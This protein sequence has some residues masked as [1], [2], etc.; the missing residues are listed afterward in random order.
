MT[1]KLIDK[2]NDL[3]IKYGIAIFAL[4]ILVGIIIFKLDKAKNAA[5]ISYNETKEKYIDQVYQNYY[6]K[7]YENAER[8]NHVSNQVAIEISDIS[9]IFS[10]EVL[11]INDVEF[12]VEN[13]KENTDN[14]T[15]WIEVPGHGIMIVNLQ[16]SEFIVDAERHYVIARVPRPKLDINQYGI[17]ADKINELLWKDDFWNGS[18]KNGESMT[19]RHLA[20][21]NRLLKED[22]RTNQSYLKAAEASANV[23][24]TNLIKKVNKDIPD[25][26]VVVE[27][28]E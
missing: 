11:C 6:S 21:A 12:I 9:K 8:E 23:L 16:E 1:T 28:I 17:D 4:V 20:E 13:P 26:K 10:L 27:F 14:I 5:E 19:Q 7:S 3:Y 24:I 15:A 18:I 25:L 2:N 22:F